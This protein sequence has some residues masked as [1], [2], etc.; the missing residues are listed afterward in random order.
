MPDE[1]EWE[2]AAATLNQRS[3]ELEAR[4]NEVGWLGAVTM[5]VGSGEVRCGEVTKRTLGKPSRFTLQIGR[6]SRREIG[7]WRS[8]A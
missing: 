4:L 6:R 3:G 7:G 2:T 8:G 5:R 1:L